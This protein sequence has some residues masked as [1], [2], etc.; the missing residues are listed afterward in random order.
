[1]EVL[2]L[3]H[4]FYG[5]VPECKGATFRFS[6]HLSHK[7]KKKVIKHSLTLVPQTYGEEEEKQQEN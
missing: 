3:L 6:L 1:L 2:A 5:Y 7:K 4:T